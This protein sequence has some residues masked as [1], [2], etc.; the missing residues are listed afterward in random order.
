MKLFG[1]ADDSDGA[2][3]HGRYITIFI[4]SGIVAGYQLLYLRCA[5]SVVRA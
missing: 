4:W 1:L 2:A 5:F 3:F